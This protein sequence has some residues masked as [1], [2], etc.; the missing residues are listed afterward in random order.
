MPE[1]VNPLL[2]AWYDIAWSTSVAVALIL[3]VIALISLSRTARSLSSRQALV[4]TF[5]TIFAPIAGPLAWLS[6]GKRSAT[7]SP[8]GSPQR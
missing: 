4:W 7:A 1:S 8:D 6:I 2:P 3:L 5:I